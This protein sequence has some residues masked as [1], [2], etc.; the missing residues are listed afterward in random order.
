M[1]IELINFEIKSVNPKTIEKYNNLIK[2]YFVNKIMDLNTKEEIQK[3]NC[4]NHLFNITAH[5]NNRK[6]NTNS[7]YHTA[8]YYY[9]DTLITDKI[10][11]ATK[12]YF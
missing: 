9:N 1:Q 10:K 12:T 8:T 4:F 7:I 5:R 3:F 11:V 6:D 2:N